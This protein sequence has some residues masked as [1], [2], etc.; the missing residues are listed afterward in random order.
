MMTQTL[1]LREPCILFGRLEVHD[2]GASMSCFCEALLH[3]VLSHDGESDSPLGPHPIKSFI[4]PKAP[5][6]MAS[7]KSNNLA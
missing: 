1:Q 2:L 3:T 7:S 6:L 5:T 4:I